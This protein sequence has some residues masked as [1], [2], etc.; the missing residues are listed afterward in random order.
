[1]S[2]PVKALLTVV[3]GSALGV[4]VVLLL[5]L[6]AGGAVGWQTSLAVGAIFGLLYGLEAGLLLSYDLTS[7]QGWL[8]LLV[9]FTWSLP[10]TLFGFVLGNIIY[11]FVGNPS[12][13]LSAGQGWIAFQPRGSGAFGNSVLQTIGTLNLGGAG[14]HERM[15]LLQARIFG[16]LYL[17][18][19]ALN[20]VVNFLVQVL[21]T[22]TVGLVLW[23]L[24]ARATP[25]LQPPG[26]SA[27]GGFFGWIYYANLFEIWAYSAGNP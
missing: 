17:P 25:Y 6:L 10:N 14:Q 11:V 3:V 27:V 1:M 9:D 24:K 12:R 5:N 13:S 7:P 4:V 20:Y 2:N 16:P 8:L 23:K 26:H 19:F 22:G 18:L 21:W 15:H